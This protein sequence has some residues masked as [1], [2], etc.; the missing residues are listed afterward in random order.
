M[1]AC[2]S[3]DGSGHCCKACGGSGIAR[4]SFDV[5]VLRK[6]DI[7]SVFEGVYSELQSER[8]SEELSVKTIMFELKG[9]RLVA[10]VYVHDSHGVVLF[11]TVECIKVDEQ[12]HPILKK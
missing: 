11:G 8:V 2:C 4:S 10:D 9:N 6:C 12:C 7:D 5:V 1:V 3:C